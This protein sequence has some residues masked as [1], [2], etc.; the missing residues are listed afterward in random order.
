MFTLTLHEQTQEIFA[1]LE[2][3]FQLT[4]THERQR[5]TILLEQTIYELEVTITLEIQTATEYWHLY[6]GDQLWYWEVWATEQITAFEIQM[7]NYVHVTITQLQIDADYEIHIVVVHY[8]DLLINIRYELELQFN[9]DYDGVI[10][11][12]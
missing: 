5:L 8:E 7:N 3:E 11:W 12:W 6:L 4:I 9:L 1:Q 10:V 2:L